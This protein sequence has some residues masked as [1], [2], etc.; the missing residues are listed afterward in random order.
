MPSGRAI[1]I[2]TRRSRRCLTYLHAPTTNNVSSEAELEMD[3]LRSALGWDLENRATERA[4]TLA[5]SLQPVWLTRGR[6]LE[7]RAWFHTILR[8][9]APE[10]RGVARP[11]TRVRSPTRPS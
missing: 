6:M 4:L 11:R 9:D 8:D 3:N 5:S 10:N 7:G 1:A 2:T